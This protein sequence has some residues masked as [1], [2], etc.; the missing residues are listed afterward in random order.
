MTTEAPLDENTFTRVLQNVLKPFL[1]ICSSSNF[2]LHNGCKY[3]S[4]LLYII[5]A[6][7]KYS[8]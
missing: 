5:A 4:L 7:E 6:V 1:D 8:I 2:F 3:G